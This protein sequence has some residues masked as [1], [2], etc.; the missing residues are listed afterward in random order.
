MHLSSTTRRRAALLGAL[1]LAAAI[2]AIGADAGA[3]AATVQ[4]FDESGTFEWTVPGDA[5]CVSVD[6]RGASGGAGTD[7]GLIDKA[8]GDEGFGFSAG[9]AGGLGGQT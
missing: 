8:P 3:Q 6:V 7:F 1:P 4:T 9:G 5:T 2:V